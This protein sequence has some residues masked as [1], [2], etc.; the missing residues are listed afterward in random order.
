MD[1]NFKLPNYKIPRT[2]LPSMRKALPR[3]RDIARQINPW[4]RIREPLKAE[5][6]N[7]VR[8]RAGNTCEWSKCNE[9]RYLDFH[10]KNMKNDDNRISNIILLCPTHHRAWHDKYKKVSHKDITTGMEIKSKV[11]RKEKYKDEKKK[12]RDRYSLIPKFDLI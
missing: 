4:Q 12:M 10:H 5:V 9:K 2:T 1:F 8:K 7:A 11:V 3:K 6:K